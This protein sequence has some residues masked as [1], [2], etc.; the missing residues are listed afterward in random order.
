MENLLSLPSSTMHCYIEDGVRRP[1]LSDIV[2]SSNPL[3][4]KIRL[5]SISCLPGSV[6]DEPAKVMDDTLSLIFIYCY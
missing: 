2:I 3:Y 1:I 5:A 4:N 6:I